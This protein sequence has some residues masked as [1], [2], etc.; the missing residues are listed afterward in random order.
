MAVKE[1]GIES[2]PQTTMMMMMTI[3]MMMRILVATFSVG[4][5]YE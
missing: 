3:M 4:L 2:P 1:M 5:C